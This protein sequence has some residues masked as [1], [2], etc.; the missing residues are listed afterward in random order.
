MENKPSSIGELISDPS[1]VRWAEGI[2]SPAE[3]ERWDQWIN[4]CAANHELARSA[5]REVLGIE[6][7]YPGPNRKNV[8]DEWEKLEKRIETRDFQSK[9]FSN[10]RKRNRSWFYRVAAVILI[11]ATLG[12]TSFIYWRTQ[13]VNNKETVRLEW[14]QI[15]T[16]FGEQKTITLTDGSV[17]TLNV[18]STL[19][20]PGG[21]M[22]NNEI[23]VLLKGEAYF[24]IAKRTSPNASA[25]KVRTLDGVVRVMGTRFM[26]SANEE[27]TR[28]VLE[29]GAVSI[30]KESDSRKIEQYK[31]KPDELAEFSRKSPSVS[32]KKVPNTK[33]FTSWTNQ[34]LMLDSS[35][36]SYL[37]DRI[38]KTYGVSVV[39][40]NEELY[41]RKLTGTIKLK[42]LDYLTQALSDVM[43][44]GVSLS[45]D[46]I[47]IGNANSK[48]EGGQNK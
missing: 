41:E 30:L 22:H 38:E 21:W 25:F 5:Q 10:I 11:S 46:T 45:E 13:K 1:F 33:V 31:L 15:K 14:K 47:Y 16:G 36:F 29:E 44:I 23:E 24:S 9:L 43:D 6:F 28:V 3:S 27:D 7:V 2:A 20:Y 32:I 8:L 19:T 35:P 26:V 48:P 39:V 4:E 12:I 42:K 37:V 18:N 40:S 34:L 17:I